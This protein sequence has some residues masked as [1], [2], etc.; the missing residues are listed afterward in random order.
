MASEETSGQQCW[1][2]PAMKTTTRAGHPVVVDDGDWYDDFDHDNNDGS[3]YD[4][5]NHDD[6]RWKG[7]G[8]GNAKNRAGG[9]G[10]GQRRQRR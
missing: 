9:G 5:D 1:Q 4:E 6:D 10:R 2:R 3:C 7:G 8:S